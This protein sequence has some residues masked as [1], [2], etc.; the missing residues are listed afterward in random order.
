MS[1][2]IEHENWRAHFNQD[3]SGEITFVMND[4][5]MP[6]VPAE[7]IIQI[8]QYCFEDEF[9]KLGQV[10]AML[11]EVNYQVRDIERLQREVVFNKLLLVDREVVLKQFA[12][13][14]PGYDERYLGDCGNAL[15][16][17]DKVTNDQSHI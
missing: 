9:K 3:L 1:H 8:F 4:L 6:D 16:W 17:L 13:R 12:E 10:R 2:T 7:L 5:I 15:K 11:D 14:I